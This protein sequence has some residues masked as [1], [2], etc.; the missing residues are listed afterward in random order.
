MVSCD[1]VPTLPV[2]TLTIGGKPYSLTGEQYV[3]KV[4]LPV[5]LQQGATERR[6][7]QQQ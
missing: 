1:K 4:R 7:L 3:L 5:G 6:L 2:I